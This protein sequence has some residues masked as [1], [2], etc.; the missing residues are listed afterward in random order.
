[1]IQ[2]SIAFLLQCIIRT[3]RAPVSGSLV[4][5]L[6]RIAQ[7]ICTLHLLFAMSH[8]PKPNNLTPAVT[9]TPL[10]R[11]LHHQ[12]SLQIKL[13]IH[14]ISHDC[15]HHRIALAI[16]TARS[17]PQ[18]GK[19]PHTFTIGGLVLGWYRLL[20]IRRFGFLYHTLLLRVFLLGL[21]NF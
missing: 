12:I 15:S 9:L 13:R 6:Y 5:L 17:A 11:R 16:I 19:R 1:M 4:A 8:F 7:D 3:P 18:G 2:C 21:C 14:W 20:C 10:F